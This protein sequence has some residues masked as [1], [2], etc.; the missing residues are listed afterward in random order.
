[1]E[2]L[3]ESYKTYKPSYQFLITNWIIKCLSDNFL[4]I[5]TE[6]LNYVVKS[7]MLESI[8]KEIQLKIK[9]IFKDNKLN[10][11]RICNYE[12]EPLEDFQLNCFN[13]NLTFSFSEFMNTEEVKENDEFP[14]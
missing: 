2:E 4:I 11:L 8:N 13:Q 14:F 3:K 5:D 9:K 12:D 10:L 6:D 7:L 1:M